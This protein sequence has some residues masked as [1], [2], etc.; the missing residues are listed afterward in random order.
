MPWPRAS[1][2]GHEAPARQVRESGYH[3]KKEKEMCGRFTFQPSE[4]FYERFQ[5]VNRLDGLVARYN[6]APGQMVPVMIANGA[7]QVR[8]MRWGLIPHWA[9]D[10]TIGYKMINARVETLTHKP[11]FRGL[12]AAHRCLVP[13]GGFY[14][15]QGQGR[16]KRPYYI[17]PRTD[18]F[19]AFAGLY[20]VWTR[21]DGAPLYTCTIITKP[22]DDV[23]ARLHHQHARDAGARAGGRLAGSRD[24]D[25][26]GGAGHPR[27]QRWCALDAYPVSRRVNRP[28]VDDAGLIQPAE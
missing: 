2:A 10:D 15:W 8:L 16:D 3:V 25:R 7:R 28:S 11:A 20:D 14:E 13:A 6:I 23:V 9:K 12:L 18:A 4:D 26:E 5:I 21:P 17:H 22:A 19:V 24:R 27:T 1:D